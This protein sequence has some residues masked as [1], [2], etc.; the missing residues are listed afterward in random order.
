MTRVNMRHQNRALAGNRGIT[1]I[2]SIHGMGNEIR[3]GFEDH[4]EKNCNL[5]AVWSNSSDMIFTPRY[6]LSNVRSE[7]LLQ[8]GSELRFFRCDPRNRG[9]LLRTLDCSI[10]EPA[11]NDIFVWCSLLASYE[12]LEL[13]AAYLVCH[14]LMRAVSKIIHLVKDNW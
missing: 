14:F 7:K 9:L 2:K 10:D 4:I 12:A 5:V 8:T 11:S 6:T 13:I 3:F 1:A